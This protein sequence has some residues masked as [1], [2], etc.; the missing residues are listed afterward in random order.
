L[1]SDEDLVK[2]VEAETRGRDYDEVILA[3]SG[4]DGSRLG[5]VA[6]STA[7]RDAGGESGLGRAS[8]RK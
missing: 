7:R 4:H 1:I 6:S 8:I 3:T 2:A 5:H